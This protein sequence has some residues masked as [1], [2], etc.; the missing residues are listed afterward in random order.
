MVSGID[1]VEIAGIV[2]SIVPLIF[3]LLQAWL[4]FFTNLVFFVNCYGVV[5]GIVWIFGSAEIWKIQNQVLHS[6]EEKVAMDFKASMQNESNMIAVAGTIVAQ[7]AITA[8]SLASLDQ[9]HWIARGLFTFSLVSSIMAVY[10]ASDQYRILGRYLRGND[11][12]TWIRNDKFGERNKWSATSVQPQLRQ[13]SMFLP[14]PAAVLTVSA[15]NVLLS[16]SLNAFLLGLGVYLGQ[17]WTK[18]L[19]EIA[20]VN[21]SCAIFITYAVSVTVCYGV[22]ALSSAV[23]VR[24]DLLKDFVKELTERK[25]NST[26][27][28][29]SN[30]RDEGERASGRNRLSGAEDV[31]KHGTGNEISGTN[32]APDGTQDLEAQTSSAP[33][34]RTHDELIRALRDAALLHRKSAAAN[35]HIAQLYE[36]LS[37][38]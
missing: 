19:D 36:S 37:H 15:P 13:F 12:R 3:A 20:G 30:P 29:S 23:V 5:G 31:L 4:E 28:A 8:L 14:S 32:P 22:Y 24:P 18:H 7:I 2:L 27:P 21:A 38:E 16:A 9:V 10:Y 33:K 17:I 26:D 1:G 35:E 34:E 25:A 6:R 11:V